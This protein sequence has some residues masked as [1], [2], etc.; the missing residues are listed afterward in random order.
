MLLQYKYKYQYQYRYKYKYC[1]LLVRRV[2]G[3]AAGVQ[4]EPI[5][6]PSASMCATGELLIDYG[7]TCTGS[8]VL[9]LPHLS[10]EKY[11]YL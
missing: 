8:D 5:L 6:V 9:M 4:Q 3:R 10:V 11:K 2:A 1:T 7:S